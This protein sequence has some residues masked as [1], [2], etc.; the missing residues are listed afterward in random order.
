MLK[1]N[2]SFIII[3][4]L[5]CFSCNKEEEIPSYIEINDFNLTSNSSFGENTENITDVWIYIDEN[6][7]GVYEIPVTFPVLNKGLQNIRI[8]AGVKANGIA[9][10][11]IQYPFYTSYLDTVELI[12]N[13]TVNIS[14]SFSYSSSFDAIVEDF[15]SSGTIIDSTINSEIDFSVQQ[16]NSNHYGYALIEEPNINFEISTQELILPQQGVPVYLELDYKSSTEF[17]VGMYINFSQDVVRRDLIWVTPK[18]EWNKIYINL[19]QTVSESIGAESFKIF[20]NMRRTDP[21]LSE[22]INFD[23]IKILY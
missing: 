10:T 9:S 11:R 18:Q 15:E 8:K 13:K 2:F 17:L 22:E 3:L 5:F 1:H 6:L 14:P 7:Q 23:N 4:I 21:S 19:T 12:E 20:L 16:N